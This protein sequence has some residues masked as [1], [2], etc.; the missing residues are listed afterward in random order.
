MLHNTKWSAQG[1]IIFLSWAIKRSKYDIH[2]EPKHF[3]RTTIVG[4]IILTTNITPDMIETILSL[5]QTPHLIL[6]LPTPI[7]P[8]FSR[9]LT[10]THFNMA[11]IYRKNLV[12]FP[13]F[14]LMIVLFVILS[15]D[16][17]VSLAETNKGRGAVDKEKL[18]RARFGIGSRPPRC[19]GKCA[20]CGRCEAIQVPTNP[21]VKADKEGIYPS[22]FD[23]YWGRRGEEDDGEGGSNYMPVSWKCKCGKFIFNPWHDNRKKMTPGFSER[24]YFVMWSYSVWPLSFGWFPG[25]VECE[26]FVLL[27]MLKKKCKCEY[28]AKIKILF[29]LG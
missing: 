3:G 16:R 2:N 1:P 17:L 20:S 4:F 13:L 18:I 19:D 24:A 5:N 15:Y 9:S 8:S 6:P 22:R 27:P 25:A 21:Q 12:S 11:F 28:I 29:F 14:S 26:L 7:T 23:N 10:S